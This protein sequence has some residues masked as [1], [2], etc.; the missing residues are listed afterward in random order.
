MPKIYTYLGMTL[1]FFSNEHEPIHIHCKY[2]GKES[3]AE[4]HLHN[5]RVVKIVIKD[6]GKGLEP[7]NRKNFEDFVKV[8]AGEIV[9][10]WIDYFVKKK[11]ITP[12]NI[13]KR[14]K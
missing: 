6:R 11:T 8:Y 4:I 5:G 2:Q 14:V 7:K 9:E 10:K 12:K 1:F 3:K 13:T